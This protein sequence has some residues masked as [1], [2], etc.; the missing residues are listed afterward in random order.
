LKRKEEETMSE[1]VIP[2]FGVLSCLS[3]VD[4]E[5]GLYLYHC[6]N[7]DIMECGKTEE[8]AWKSVKLAVKYYV[9]H[10]YQFYQEGF[11][12]EA[13]REQWGQFAEAAKHA[14]RPPRMEVIEFE[15]KPPLPENEVPVW[16]QGVFADGA[17]LA[18]IQ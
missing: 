1:T 7:F 9:E 14:T 16:M 5:T 8:E 12:Q 6:L 3:S 15:L 13:P 10:C 11:V 2:R 18:H 4:K 17:S